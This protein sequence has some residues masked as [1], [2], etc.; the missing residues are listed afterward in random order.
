MKRKIILLAIGLMVAL[1]IGI[2]FTLYTFWGEKFEIVITEAELKDKIAEKFPITRKY[3]IIFDITYSDPVLHLEE[4]GD[5]IQVG[6]T[7]TTG[8]T[9]N[10]KVFSGDGVVSGSLRY[11]QAS[12]SFF[13]D[14]LI[15]ESLA[16][17]G[18][19][20]KYHKEVKDLSTS[21]LRSYYDKHPLYTLKSTDLKQ[22]AARLILKSVVVRHK[23]L[24]VTMGIG[25]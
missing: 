4:G 17:A 3:L 23:T 2:A 16:I 14:R 25:Q 18:F 12:G 13:L 22:R 11:D 8:F 1:T 24:V 15:L 9:L 21:S 7:A 19:P 10:N 5:R 6:I 20:E